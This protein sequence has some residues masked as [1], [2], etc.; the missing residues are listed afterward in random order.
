MR[1][2]KTV[3]NYN[4]KPFNLELAIE[5]KTPFSAAADTDEIIRDM[6]GGQV[7]RGLS[8]HVVDKI[9]YDRYF[10]IMNTCI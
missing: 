10:K 8:I 2:R 6:G 3:N 9:L 7:A 1:H 4:Y 5:D